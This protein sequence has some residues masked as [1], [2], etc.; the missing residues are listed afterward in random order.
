MMLL[1]SRAAVSERMMPGVEGASGVVVWVL[2]GLKSP[3]RGG[4]VFGG[5]AACTE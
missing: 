1:I 2:I 4:G 5:G 3:V